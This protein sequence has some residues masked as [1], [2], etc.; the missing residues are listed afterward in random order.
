MNI[1][2]LLPT[3]PSLTSLPTAVCADKR[4]QGVP[5]VVIGNKADLR[6]KRVLHLEEVKRE[7]TAYPIEDFIECTNASNVLSTYLV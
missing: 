1:K 4:F 2:R 3:A 7:M 6:E 5:I